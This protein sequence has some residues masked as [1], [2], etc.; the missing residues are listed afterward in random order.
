MSRMVCARSAATARISRQTSRAGLGVEAGRG[1]VEEQHAGL[2]HQPHGDVQ[3]PLHPTGVGA[4]NAVGGVGDPEPLEQLAG[5]PAQRRAVEAVQRALQLEILAAGRLRVAAVL[6]A[7]DPDGRRT[8]AGSRSAS[9]PA[10]RTRPLSGTARV[11]R[12]RTVVDLPAPFGP[13]SANSVPG[14]IARLTPSSART[15]P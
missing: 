11:V 5:A 8:R 1:L 9:M 12:M 7:D 4:H 2:V 10:T 6:L 3:P 14:S 15:S 13:S